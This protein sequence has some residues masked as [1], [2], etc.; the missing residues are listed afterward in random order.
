MPPQ[1]YVDIVRSFN[2]ACAVEWF[3]KF[4]PKLTWMKSLQSL[5]LIKLGPNATSSDSGERVMSPLLDSLVRDYLFPPREENEPPSPLRRVWIQDFEVIGCPALR[6]SST[7]SL[8]SYRSGDCGDLNDED[9][10]SF[11]NMEQLGG[12][13]GI[14]FSHPLASLQKLKYASGTSTD[15]KKVNDFQNRNF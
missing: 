8:Q 1:E 2:T 9:Y 5:V 15:D 7:N 3:P 14:N 10:E 13:I 12:M 11:T 4:A 6:N